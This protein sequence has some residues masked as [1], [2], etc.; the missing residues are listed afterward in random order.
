[1]FLT[2]STTAVAFFATCIC[3]VSPILCFAAFCGMMIIFNYVMNILIVFPALCIYDNWIQK[4]SRNW[5]ITCSRKERKSVPDFIDQRK[6]EMSLLHRIL[7]I[8]ADLIHRYRWPLLG[9]Y[10]VVISV[11]IHVALTISLPES[12]VVRVLPDEHP[13][14]TLFSWKQALLSTAL[15]AVGPEIQIHFGL[16]PGD[17]GN[18]NDPGESNSQWMQAYIPFYHQFSHLLFRLSLQTF[19]RVFELRYAQRSTIDARKK[20]APGD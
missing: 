13:L 16:I 9:I 19:Q 15:F 14:E 7:T 20:A 18:P 1:M 12:S 3:P 8:Y 4:G 17:T 5:L 2:T 11:C 6:S 10:I